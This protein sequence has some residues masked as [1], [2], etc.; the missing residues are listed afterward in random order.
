MWT[1]PN[2]VPAH[3]A[4]KELLSNEVENR[5]CENDEVVALLGDEEK[6]HGT[7]GESQ[8]GKKQPRCKHCTVA[9]V[10]EKHVPEKQRTSIQHSQENGH[11][12]E[13]AAAAVVVELGVV[14]NHGEGL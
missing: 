1:S 4:G 13:H 3:T 6:E 2:G 7:C 10:L 14:M 9:Q 12:I 11:E 5:Q 8:D